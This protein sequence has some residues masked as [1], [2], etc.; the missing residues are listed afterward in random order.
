MLTQVGGLQPPSSFPKQANILSALLRKSLQ[1]LP[2]LGGG[3]EVLSGPL[4]QSLN[5]SSQA[6]FTHS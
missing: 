3:G 5:Y 2:T 1:S 6:A 4:H